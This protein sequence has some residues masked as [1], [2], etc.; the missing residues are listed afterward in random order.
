MVSKIDIYREV[1]EIEPNSKVFFPLARQLHEEGRHDEAATVLAR[2][3]AFHPDH[4]EAKFLL[5]ELLTRLGRA[6]EADA[7]FGDVGTM[8]ARYPSVWLL[9]SREA[10]SRSTDPALAMLFLANYFQNETLTWADVMERGLRSLRQ[11]APGTPDLAGKAAATSAS[12]PDDANQATP[13][14]ET[15]PVAP[16][17]LAPPV[18]RPQD[19]APDRREAGEAPP[20]R[21]AREVLELADLLDVPEESREK[22]RP[23]PAKP[24]EA[25]VRTKTMAALL[26]GQGETDAA[27]DIYTE[28]LAATAPGPERQELERM[29][30]SLSPGGAPAADLS[31]GQ[32]ESDLEEGDAPPAVAPKPK[33]AAKLVSLLEALAGRLESRAGA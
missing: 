17:P 26:A 15:A 29:L 14:V 1:L 19:P 12:P 8:L 9:W 3:I 4:L 23:R 25:G 7:V 6:G 13:K 11:G 27:R 22:A 5:I 20:L 18:P 30:A 16:A 31:A 24:R 32:P 33:G 28:L 10:A 2:G 21:G